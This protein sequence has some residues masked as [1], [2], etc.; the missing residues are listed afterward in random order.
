MRIVYD[1]VSTTPSKLSDYIRTGAWDFPVVVPRDL[2]R[3]IRTLPPI[4]AATDDTV[5]GTPSGTGVFTSASARDAIRRRSCI[6]PWYKV[7]R[8][9]GYVPRMAAI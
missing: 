9:K 8:F 7:V 6:V 4:C 3:V 1:A 5:E 2:D